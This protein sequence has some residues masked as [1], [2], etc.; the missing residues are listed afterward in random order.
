MSEL[1]NQTLSG[2]KW[3][4]LLVFTNLIL[5][6]LMIFI[7]GYILEPGDFGLRAIIIFVL[8]LSKI[9]T[10]FGIS[11]AIIQHEQ[12]TR[13][14]LNSIF[15]VNVLSGVIMFLCVNLSASLLAEYYGAGEL[16]AL[17]HSASLLFLIEPLG[18]VFIALLE[19]RL[20]F[21]Q[22]ALINMNKTWIMNVTIILF[23]LLGFQVYSFI[24]GQFLSSLFII[25][26]LFWIFRKNKDWFPTLY[27]NFRSLKP[28]YAFG[29][30]VSGK[31]ILNYFGRNFDEL[32]VG[33]L[34]GIDLLGYYSFAKQVLDRVI[35][36]VIQ[37]ST[38][39]TYPVFCKIHQGENAVVQF[40]KMYY[41]MTHLVASAGL[42]VFAILFLVIPTAVPVV[43]GDKW[44]PSIIVMQVLALKGMVDILSAGFAT[45]ALYA[46]HSS[47]TAFYVD[48]ILLP[49]RLITLVI[50]CYYGLSAVAIA[51]LLFVFLK[52]GILQVQV[53]RVCHMSWGEYLSQLRS[54]FL[55]ACGL[56]II[57]YGVQQFIDQLWLTVFI[58]PVYATLYVLL[59][60]R[61]NPAIYKE[62][63]NEVRPMF[64]KLF[65]RKQ[66]N[67]IRDGMGM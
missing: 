65:K 40:R 25:I 57:S 16:K 21:K 47:K 60:Y 39:V 43:F 44:E 4:G 38:K 20:Q 17:L 48:L 58:V 28:Y 13:T 53:N 37:I 64:N 9:I 6:S 31:N 59:T 19:K 34:L 15:T 22:L 8:G 50:A 61:F 33:K 55:I 23:A 46:H 10:D 3:N 11:Q 52:A 56:T 63:A 2:F 67:I 32:I 12:V 66:K 49:V 30:Y 36:L 54:P 35:D 51:Y 42:P 27:L 41:K 5:N 29:I 7:L 1:K 62:V 26:S 14:E 24:I 45:N 18:V